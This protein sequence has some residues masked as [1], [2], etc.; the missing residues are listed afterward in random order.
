MAVYD[1]DA[2]VEAELARS[3]ELLRLERPCMCWRDVTV[4]R[5]G[6]ISQR[7][8]GPWSLCLWSSDRTWQAKSTGA[9][10][11]L[12]VQDK[13]AQGDAQVPAEF[14][15]LDTRER[16][17]KAALPPDVNVNGGDEL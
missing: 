16:D 14:V 7:R 13:M 9:T 8:K 17:L 12:L 1:E 11:R 15:M 3:R 5:E 4:T 6:S 10:R 2:A